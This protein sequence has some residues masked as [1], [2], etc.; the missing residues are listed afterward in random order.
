MIN[1]QTLFSYRSKAQNYLIDVFKFKFNYSSRAGNKIY[2]NDI[3]ESTHANYII[4]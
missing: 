1:D 2:N 4:L 3:I